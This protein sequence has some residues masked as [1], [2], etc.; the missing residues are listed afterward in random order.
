VFVRGRSLV[1]GTAGGLDQA[2]A[3][4][5]ASLS[6]EEEGEYREHEPGSKKSTKKEQAH[7]VIARN[8]VTKQS[9]LFSSCICR[10]DEIAAPA[11]R[12]AQVGLAMT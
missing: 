12:Q 3:F 4:Q 10:K 2:L 6:F 9:H 1:E 7:S 11:L 8:E 5:R